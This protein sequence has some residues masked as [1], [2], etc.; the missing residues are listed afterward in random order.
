MYSQCVYGKD[1]DYEY[2]PI[3]E[4]NI[5]ELLPKLCGMK[6]E[7]DNTGKRLTRLPIAIGV[8]GSDQ[9]PICLRVPRY[10]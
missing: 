9:T 4:G 3:Q 5:C 8:M 6:R 7:N 2:W 1:N 10:V